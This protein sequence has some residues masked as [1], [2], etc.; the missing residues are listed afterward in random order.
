MAARS[1]RAPRT[2]AYVFA[3][4]VTALAVL[5]AAVALTARQAAPPA[6]AEF[7]PQAVEQIKQTLDEQAPDVT[8]DTDGGTDGTGPDA[9]PSASPSPAAVGPSAAASARPL[10]VE[11]P[12]VRQ[13]VGSPPR[14]TEDP[15]SP[16]C[17]PYFDPKLSNGGATSPGVTK[18][19]ITVVLPQQFFEDVSIPPKL[20]AFFNKRY[21]FYGRKLVL[22]TYTPAGCANGVPSPEKQRDDAIAVQEE[23]QAFASLAYCNANSADRAYY[24]A[25]AEKKVI[26]VP[27]GNLIT[28]TEAAYARRAPYEWNVQ[29]GVNVVLASTAQFVCSKLAG[30]KP[31]YAGPAQRGAAARK[32]GVIYTRATDG[33]TPDLEPLRTGLRSCGVALTEV[34]EDA[35]ADSTRNGV[36]AVVTMRN[37]GVPPLL[38]LCSI[39]DTRGKY[40]TAATG[41]GYQPEWIETSYGGNDIDNSYSGGNA[42]P[43]QSSHVLGLTFR[44][45]L[46][47]KQDMPWYWAVREA[48]PTS[49][50]QG[51]TYYASNSRYYQLL[52]LASGIQLAGPDLTPASFQ[53]GLQ[54]ARFP[55]PGA[56]GAP[57]FQARVGFEGRRHVMSVDA[58]MFWYDPNR[59]GTIDPTVPGSICYVDRGR[60]YTLGQWT[61]SDP[62]FFTGP[63]L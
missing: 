59:P 56:A 46:L 40:M 20:V 10:A 15:Q 52:L 47:P 12:R 48:D 28:G 37:A 24:D 53:R 14:Q 4:L 60:R 57:Y 45:K 7:A 3:G 33:S 43:D 32:F 1:G 9:K 35:T 50:P 63:C 21:E 62:G 38:C 16:P 29:A 5:V 36:N 27:D 58:A 51:N 26:S 34:R 22:K 54:A 17:V 13:C 49:D 30:R 55:N 2:P 6:I 8:P 31:A 11:V 25:L 44:N 42:P 23:L 39:A 61:R 19:Q 41:Q 18:D